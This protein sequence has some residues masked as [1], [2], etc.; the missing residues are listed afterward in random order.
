M[1]VLSTSLIGQK[2]GYYVMFFLLSI[3]QG[4]QYKLLQQDIF[5]KRV[6]QLAKHNEIDQVNLTFSSPYNPLGFFSSSNT[7]KLTYRNRTSDAWHTVNCQLSDNATH[8]EGQIS[9]VVSKEFR[10]N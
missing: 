1:I 4:I 6:T 10:V 3:Y 8:C 7:L 2:I 5:L 9:D